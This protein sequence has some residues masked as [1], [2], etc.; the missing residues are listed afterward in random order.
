MSRC[1][2]VALCA[3]FLATSASALEPF[4]EDLMKKLGP[5]PAK[6]TPAQKDYWCRRAVF[7]NYGQLD[8]TTDSLV[9]DG[10]FPAPLI[11]G[12]VRSNGA[13]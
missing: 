10:M 9:M 4:R 7:F 12:C 1:I 13:F 6:G 8:P 11:D 5:F 3:I 2:A